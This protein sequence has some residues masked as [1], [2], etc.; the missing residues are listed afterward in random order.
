MIEGTRCWIR[1]DMNP[2]DYQDDPVRLATINC[3][4]RT[5]KIRYFL[6]GSNLDFDCTHPA[7][8]NKNN[9]STQNIDGG[10]MVGGV[11]NFSTFCVPVD[12]HLRSLGK[13]SQLIID[14]D[15]TVVESKK[16]LPPEAK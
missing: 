14:G 5:G 12:M 1:G 15:F 2:K 8:L 6:F 10:V 7:V 13:P 16:S 4:F 11:D 9:N 3:P